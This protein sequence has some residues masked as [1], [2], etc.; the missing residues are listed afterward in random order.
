ML[1]QLR[2]KSSSPA[3]WGHNPGRYRC[4]GIAAKLTI[5]FITQGTVILD[6]TRGDAPGRESVVCSQ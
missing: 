3:P 5:N 2:C 6:W 1:C 4:G